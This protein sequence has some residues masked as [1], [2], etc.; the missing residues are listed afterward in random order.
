MPALGRAREAGR[1]TACVG[2]LRQV[3]IALQL[4]VQDNGNRMPILRD[5][6]LEPP[7]GGASNAVPSIDS[8]LSPHL[9][10]TQALR[11]PSDR[12]RIFE[13]TGSSYSWNNL[14]NGQDAEHLQALGVPFD[15]H[16]IPV[17]FDKES[18]HRARGP[19]KGVNYLYA[20]GHV[21]KLFAGQA[22]G[23]RQA[24]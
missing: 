6:L 11:C 21:Q 15:P 9:G 23:G 18:F 3:G 13:R 17:V 16:Q 22:T 24:P 4:Y 1:A 12:S 19:G 20:D 2:N 14:L 5:R 7:P 8:A 10:S